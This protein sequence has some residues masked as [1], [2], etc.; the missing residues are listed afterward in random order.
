M[1]IKY[2]FVTGAVEVEV[3]D[4][5][6][7]ILVDLDRQEYN[8]NHKETR[9]HCSLEAY[10][11]DDGLLPSSEDVVRDIFAAEEQRH[12]HEAIGR[13]EPRQQ[14]LIRQIYF[15]GRTFTSIAQEEGVDRTAVSKATKRAVRKLKNFL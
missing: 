9:R 3:T 5:W 6:G 12:L 8:I 1:K 11:L 14:K 13:L 7:T 2:E 10:N 15:E 4:D